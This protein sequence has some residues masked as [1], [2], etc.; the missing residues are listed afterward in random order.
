MPSGHRGQTGFATHWSVPILLSP[1]SR[2]PRDALPPLFT[3]EIRSAGFQLRVRFLECGAYRPLDIV[4]L[5]ADDALSGIAA[6]FGLLCVTI[7]GNYGR[8]T[9]DCV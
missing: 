6:L 7:E 1:S 4:R 9:G 2:P 8:L 5:L 3:A